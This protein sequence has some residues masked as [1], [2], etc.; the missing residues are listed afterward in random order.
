MEI[1]CIGENAEEEEEEEEEEELVGVK[2]DRE[3]K[4]YKLSGIKLSGWWFDLLFNDS[5]QRGDISLSISTVC[6][7]AI[8]PIV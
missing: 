6:S 7:P 1:K 8:I 2:V 4:S 5:S 3:V